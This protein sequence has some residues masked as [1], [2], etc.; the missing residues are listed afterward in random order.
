MQHLLHNFYFMQKSAFLLK[1][2]LKNGKQ[3]DTILVH[4]ECNFIQYLNVCLPALTY[5]H[6]TTSFFCTYIIFV[7]SYLLY[8]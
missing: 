5:L 1:F 7:W 4:K 2:L 3:I 6:K 8:R